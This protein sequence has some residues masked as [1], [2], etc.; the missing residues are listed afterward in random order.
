M[1]NQR[2]LNFIKQGERQNLEFQEKA[3]EKDKGGYN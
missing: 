1:T 3:K 2:L